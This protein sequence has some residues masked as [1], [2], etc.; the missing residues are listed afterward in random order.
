[1][2]LIVVQPLTMGPIQKNSLSPEVINIYI[3][4]S[5]A[6][7]VGEAC[8]APSHWS[9]GY[10]YSKLIKYTYYGRIELSSM[11]LCFH[12]CPF[13]ILF[14]H[15]NPSSLFSIFHICPSCPFYR[16]SLPHFVIIVHVC[17]IISVI[18]HL[19]PLFQHLKK[20]L[21]DPS[22]SNSQFV[23]LVHFSFVHLVLFLSLL[24][25]VV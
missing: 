11:Y 8:P 13:L 14:F 6:L 7:I 3:S 15:I 23:M 25:V 2:A 19:C 16:L 9:S 22:R 17:P 4:F 10:K 12:I 21:Y 18:C 24:F 5:G 20:L 1:M